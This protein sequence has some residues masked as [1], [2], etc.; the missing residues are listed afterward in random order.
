MLNLLTQSVAVKSLNLDILEAAF[1]LYLEAPQ[2]SHPKI[3]LTTL[4]Q[5]TGA[6]PLK[7]RNAIVDACKMGRFPNCSLSA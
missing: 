4:S 7:C 6:S 1:E 5:R 2:E 3:S